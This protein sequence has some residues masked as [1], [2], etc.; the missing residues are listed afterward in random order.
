MSAN[1]FALLLS[2]ILASACDRRTDQAPPPPAE[3][4]GEPSIKNEQASGTSIMRPEVAEEVAAPQPA[5]PAAEPL[6]LVIAFR[7]GAALDDSAREALQDLIGQPAFA[8]G[9]AITVSGHSDASGSDSDNLAT[10]RRRA[11]AVRDYLLSKGV[12]A[13]R[14]TLIALGERRPIAPN[15]RP[16]G[17]DDPEGRQRNRR[18]DLIV[19]PPAPATELSPTPPAG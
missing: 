3:I 5:A 8:A 10:S 13:A 17:S 14:I 1:R 18:V 6:R 15:A 19:A 12:E 7:Q 9:G 16:D 4:V 2:F 11:E